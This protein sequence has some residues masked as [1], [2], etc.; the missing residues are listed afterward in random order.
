METSQRR[1]ITPPPMLVS[2]TR[3]VRNWMVPKE[4]LCYAALGDYLQGTD[5]EGIRSMS[6]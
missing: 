3:G 1:Q 6:R 2:K 5:A 4:A